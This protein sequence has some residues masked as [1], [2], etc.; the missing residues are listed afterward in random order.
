MRRLNDICDVAIR[1]VRLITDKYTNKSRGF[2][3]VE[4][5]STEDGRSL[6]TKITKM[7]PPFEIGSRKV[8]VSYQREPTAAKETNQAAQS[9]IAAAQWSAGA[10]KTG[11]PTT[12]TTPTTPAVVEKPA[13]V[14]EDPADAKMPLQVGSYVYDEKSGFYYDSASGL[15]YDPK[16]KYYYNP[17]DQQYYF[18]DA[19]A[20]KYQSLTDQATPSEETPASVPSA[21]AAV[22]EAGKASTPKA[23]KAM[24]AKKIQKDMERWAKAKNR[25]QA[26]AA[27]NRL[28]EEEEETSNVPVGNNIALKIA[29]G[30]AGAV[31]QPTPQA[32]PQTSVF[33]I[34]AIS[35][36]PAALTDDQISRKYEDLTAMACLL[37]KRKFPSLDNLRRHQ[38]LSDL[39][40]KGLAEEKEKNAGAPGPPAGSGYKDRAQ[41]RREKFGSEAPPP[42]KMGYHAQGGR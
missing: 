10:M 38:E 42:K 27:P 7:D 40:Q 25:Q 31:S 14:K 30:Y 26:K 29:Q 9:A 16:T 24:N 19:V 15:Y 33:P 22:E 32:P 18:W 3:F 12:A 23:S 4:V 1:D 35:T 13:V 21:K 20:N 5:T 28:E 2:C 34:T 11:A 39:H 36:A 17:T 41:E 8:N 37:C 6:Y